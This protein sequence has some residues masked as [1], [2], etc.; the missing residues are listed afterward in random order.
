[1]KLVQSLLLTALVLA[2]FSCG[3]SYVLSPEELEEVLVDIHLA[4]GIAMTSAKDF[5]KAEQ[6]LDLYNS[7]YASHGIDKAKF[8]STISYYTR[9][10]LMVLDDIYT[11]VIDRIT[12]LEEQTKAG[13]FAVT[14]ETISKGIHARICAEDMALL[15]YVAS[16][17]WKGKRVVTFSKADLEKG[18]SYTI[19]VDTTQTKTMELRFTIAPDSLKAAAC[20]VTLVY[21]EDDVEKAFDLPVDSTQLVKLTWEIDSIPPI[22]R[23]DFSADKAN[24]NAKLTL[25][26]LRLYS[27]STKQ[28]NTSLFR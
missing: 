22:V 18:K 25:K 4:E 17:Y 23:F 27:L 7:V 24:D 9:E 14:K 20:T 5:R 19:D 26:D 28:N 3:N 6:K 21:G 10:D 13:H 2:L 16:E 1:M 11:H 12:E 15:P 8:D